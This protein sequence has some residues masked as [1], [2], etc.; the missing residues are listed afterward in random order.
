MPGVNPD[1]IRRW[2]FVINGGG[3]SKAKLTH[4]LTS[5]LP[6]TVYK[7]KRDLKT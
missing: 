1:V 3:N 6:D 2:K 4:V 7:G 5:R